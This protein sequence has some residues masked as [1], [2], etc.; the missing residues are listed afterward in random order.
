MK[1]YTNCVPDEFSE[2]CTSLGSNAKETDPN[3][4]TPWIKQQLTFD[5]KVKGRQNKMVPLRYGINNVLDFVI[6]VLVCYDIGGRSR[7]LM[8]GCCLDSVLTAA[9]C[10]GFRKDSP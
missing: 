10:H 4:F 6:T 5:V 7:C 1:L 9:S 8:L 2:A 3:Y